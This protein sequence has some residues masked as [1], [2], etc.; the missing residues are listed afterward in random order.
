[1]QA[2]SATQAQSAQPVSPAAPTY[3]NPR[4][5]FDRELG[6]M[7]MQVRDDATG[8]VVTQFPSETIVREYRRQQTHQTRQPAGEKTTA[9]AVTVRS[10]GNRQSSGVEIEA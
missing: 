2:G 9:P 8:E 10:G 3:F 6:L 1:M 7:I 4:F 5:S